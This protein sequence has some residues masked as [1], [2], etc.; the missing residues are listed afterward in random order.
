MKA[1][2]EMDENFAGGRFYCCCEIVDSD[3]RTNHAT[4]AG[5]RGSPLEQSQQCEKPDSELTEAN[6]ITLPG[7]RLNNLN[8]WL[9]RAMSSLVGA[10]IVCPELGT[11]MNINNLDAN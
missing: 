5:E 11:R 7:Q 8:K 1:A 6:R 9:T 10:C 3:L 4:M 2:A